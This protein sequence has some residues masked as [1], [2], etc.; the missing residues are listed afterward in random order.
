MTENFELVRDPAIS[1]KNLRVDY[2]ETLAVD[3]VNL[4]IPQ[5]EIFG[6]V[7]PNGAGKTSTFK[8]LATLMRP[9][10]G[11]VRL[12]GIDCLS[13]PAAVRDR[14]AY[15][16]DLAPLPSDLRCHEF[17]D[18]FAAAYGLGAKQRRTRIDEVLAL[19]DLEEK[20]KM[21]CKA[22]SRGMSQRLVLAKSLLHDPEILI[23]DE[24]A[25]GMDPASR[26][27]LRDILKHVT[28]A[29]STVIISSHILSELGT[30]CTSIGLMHRGRLVKAGPVDEV[31]EAMSGPANCLAI[32]F[33]DS[34]ERGRVLLQGLEGVE[35]VPN[36]KANT[37]NSLTVNFDGTAETQTRLLTSLIEAG[38]KVRTFSEVGSTIEDIFLAIGEQ[39]LERHG[40]HERQDEVAD[41]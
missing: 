21:P 4:E 15:M 27:N 24:P 7:G 31:V 1:I 11:E 37:P 17:L 8:V 26:A 18:L 36:P 32:R 20:R 16:P 22:L 34:A 12:G 9:T 23:L 40:S 13:K 3:N 33:W 2:G 35:L 29:G 25:S 14:M 38:C 41:R 39:G 5:G 6:L 19:V 30:M 10:L 28:E